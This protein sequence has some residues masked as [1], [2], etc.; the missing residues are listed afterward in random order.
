[1]SEPR[2]RFLSTCEWVTAGLITAIA[3]C[4]HLVRVRFAGP[5]WR[6]E[7]AVL[8]L[9]RMNWHEIVS[10]FPHEGFPPPFL[11]LLREY[12]GF[13]G[14]SDIAL[15][16]FGLCAGTACLGMVWL[17]AA[18]T[19]RRAP[20]LALA[21][22]GFNP[23]LFV[24]GD[25]IRGYGLGA[26]LILL[27]FALFA[28]AIVKPSHRVFW[29]ALASAVLS[30]QC[31]LANAV[32]LLA[33]G[34]SALVV[35][36]S[37]RRARHARI[38]VGIGCVTALSIIPYIGSYRNGREWDVVFR[39]RLSLA[40]LWRRL[41]GA[42][43]NPIAG[44][45]WVWWILLVLASIGM[46]WLLQHNSARKSKTTP[47]AGF[48]FLGCAL[49]LICYLTFLKSLGYPT[50][51]WYYL[52]LIA[53][54]VLGLDIVA[55]VLAERLD[56]VAVL[57]LA[58]AVG[59]TAALAAPAF[60][61]AQKRMSNLDLVASEL[62][63]RA[64]PQDFIVVTPWY[65]GISFRSHSP[66]GM[67]WETLPPMRDLRLHRY[68]LLKEQMTLPDPL[69]PV[70]RRIA[71]TLRSGHRLW[72]VGAL[73]YPEPGRMPP[74]HAPA[75]HDRVGWSEFAYST[76]WSMQLGHF[77][78]THGLRSH[79]VEVA[80]PTPINVFENAQLTAVEGWRGE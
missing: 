20:L 53:V 58:L 60:T 18:L 7:V 2:S 44:I 3:L 5:L 14:T 50:Q 79:R 72:I 78:E 30:V 10:Y 25:S 67:A 1:M 55:G 57:R 42:L 17:N 36:I 59:V 38:V 29:A 52:S 11:A 34:A 35:L 73:T 6:D 32:L 37:E 56:W 8:N 43:G 15:R 49:A 27:T 69:E 9:A 51:D 70:R 16:V 77:V 19:T 75:P 22:L 71:E 68:D 41:C 33:L 28:R 39:T 13:L 4:L 23:V 61:E 24:W 63:R 64:A 74:F 21:L 62:E 80:A 66:M 31:L 12:A 47:L 46:V 54:L 45:R 76:A 40:L 48:A 65:L 26:A